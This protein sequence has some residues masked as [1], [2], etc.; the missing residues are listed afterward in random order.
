MNNSKK[1]AGLAGIVSVLWMGLTAAVAANQKRLLFNPLGSK[2]EVFK[3]YSTGHRTRPIVVR[4][5]DG[6]RLSGWLMTPPVK[7][8]HP[9]VVYFGGRSEE[10]SWVARDAGKLFPG[11][12]VLAVNYRGYG[13]SHGDPA[14]EHF[15]D[16]GRMLF[17]WL[18]ERHHVDPKR[19]AVV[20]RSLGS[21][22]AVQVAMERDA[23]AIVLI[24][25][26][27]SILAIAKR[28]F[29][30]IPVEYVLRHKF[31]SIKY[32]HQLLAPTY[33]LRAAFDD[34]VPHSHTDL[35]VQKLGKLHADEIV[36]DSDHMNIPYLE[37]TQDRIASFLS[38]RFNQPP[39]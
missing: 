11:M 36:P 14:E 6:T 30:A 18:S 31:E 23:S 37:A 15:V 12:A 20:G 8:P 2:R 38:S 1:V 7:G 35:L 27:D 22:V 39:A 24:T 21:G 3:P 26:Y 25:P 19:I 4:S 32:A 16:D 33:V 9:G 28:K 34:V 5:K 13:D 17:D 10:V 29:K